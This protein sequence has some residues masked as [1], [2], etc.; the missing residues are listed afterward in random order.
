VIVASV[1]GRVLADGARTSSPYLRGE[2]IT[3][4][5]DV[6]LYRAKHADNDF[7]NRVELKE[8]LTFVREAPTIGYGTGSIAE[9]FRRSSVDETGAASVATRQS[10]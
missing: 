5:H 8:S 9:M 6:Q 2:L 4:A 7:G 3:A 1:V 10:P